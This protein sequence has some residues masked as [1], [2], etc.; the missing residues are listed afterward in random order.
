[1]AKRIAVMGCGYVGLLAAVGLSDFGNTCVGIDINPDKVTQLQAGKSPIYEPGLDEYLR[2]NL[3]SG[4]LS[5]TSDPIPALKKAQVIF[6][7]VGTPPL[8]NGQADLTFILAAADS[9][10]QCLKEDPE[11][12][13]V[14]VIKSTVPVGTNRMIRD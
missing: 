8:P 1:M 3:D 14:V 13:K 4:R 11:T 7:T 6:I 10:A 5:F 2:R 12:Y 9:I